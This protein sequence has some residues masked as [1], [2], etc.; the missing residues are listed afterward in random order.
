VMALLLVLL[1][2][3]GPPLSGE[4]VPLTRPATVPCRSG[5]S[6]VPDCAWLAFRFT[7][8]TA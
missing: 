5:G 2:L 7:G 3:A 6:G 1:L 4:L 8:V